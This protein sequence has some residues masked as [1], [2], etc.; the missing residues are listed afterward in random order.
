[1]NK[2]KVILQ[3][4][5]IENIPYDERTRNMFY[6]CQGAETMLKTADENYFLKKGSFYDFFTYFNALSLE[7]WKMYTIAEDISLELD[8]QGKFVLDLMGHYINGRNEIEKEWLGRYYFDLKERQKITL[9]YPDFCDCSVVAFQIA[10]LK[11]TYFYGAC[12]VARAEKE[13]IKNPQITMVTTTFQKEKYIFK[14]AEI[15]NQTL[16]RDPVF[17]EH[18]RWKIIDNGSTLRPQDINNEHIKVL[19][20]KNV[21]GAG[22]F[23][24]GMMEALSSEIKSTH[25][26]LMDD[27]VAF[28]PDSFKRL[29]TLLML[30]KPEYDEYFV[31][32]AMLEI[33]ERNIQHEDVGFL[34]PIG[35]HG[36]VKP[37]YDLN[38]WDSVVRNET[39]VAPEPHRYAGWWYCCIPARFVRPDN[40]PL[41]FFIRGDDVEYSVRNHARFIT[42]NGICIWHEGFGNK[43]SGAMELYQVHRNDLILQSLREE[44]AD[45]NVIQRIIW[46]FWEEMYKFNYRGA[47][48]LLDAVEDYLKGPE[49]LK[50]LNGQEY[51]KEKRAQDNQLLPIPDEVRGQIDYGR[52][53]QRENLSRLQKFLYDYSC[54][55][56]RLPGFLSKSKPGI[57]PY[58]WG[59]YQE[60]QYLTRVNYAVDPVNNLYV[61]YKKSKK[62]YKALKRRFQDVYERYQRENDAV[63][64]AYRKAEGQMESME[65]WRGYLAWQKEETKNG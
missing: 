22:G 18:F 46:L 3:E 33:N 56:H 10:A 61:V 65:F 35:T 57:I 43:F 6:R 13:K 32:G 34:S 64:E 52:L 2:E 42:M 21:G 15:L 37:R 60:K 1:M 63:T 8:I 12:Y 30:I 53:Y 9:P 44:V 20:N 45:S 29:C 11:N 54:N 55:G 59:Y 58:G 16:F 31:S 27:D 14:N 51:M 23:T 28:L 62:E 49:F 5:M 7:K 19:H 40:L 26:L 17:T 36:P 41:P 25:I 38:L 50:T 47:A 39:I 24:R 48:L 4:I